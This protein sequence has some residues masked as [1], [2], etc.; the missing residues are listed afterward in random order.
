MGYRLSGLRKLGFDP[1]SLR[2]RHSHLAVVS[3]DAWGEPASS[4]LARGFD[5]I[6]QAGTGIAYIY[7]SS[8]DG[9]WRPGSLPV[10]ALDHATGMGTAAATLALIAARREGISGSAHLS[11]ARTAIE[12]LSFHKPPSPTEPMLKQVRRRMSSDYGLLEFSP[13]PITTVQSEIEFSAAPVIYGS[14]NLEWRKS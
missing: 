13:P 7:G 10:Q 4:T 3:L 11:L 9:E 12:L 14:S 8:D 5:S 1:I 6:V 2:E